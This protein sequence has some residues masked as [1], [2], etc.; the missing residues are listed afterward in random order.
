VVR[1]D[2]ELLMVRRNL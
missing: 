1:D 2:M